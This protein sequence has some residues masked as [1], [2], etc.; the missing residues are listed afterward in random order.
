MFGISFRPVTDEE[1]L[2]QRVQQGEADAAEQLYRRHVRY[3]TALCSRYISD[4]E[5]IKDILQDSFLKIFSSIGTFKYRG[6]GSLRGWMS[7]ITLNES[8]KFLRRNSYLDIVDVD[9]DEID[10]A[11]EDMETNDIPTDVLFRLVQDLPVGYR[12]VLNLCII[13]GKSHREIADLLGI[14]ENTSASQL[15]KAKAQLACKIKQYRTAN[16]I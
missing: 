2:L 1:R 15:H 9:A 8:L 11:D 5:D 7:K 10:M 13:E 14:K 16:S 3:L 12:T 4:D 6:K